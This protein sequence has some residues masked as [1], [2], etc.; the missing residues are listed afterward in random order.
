LKLTAHGGGNKGMIFKQAGGG[1][2]SVFRWL[3][4][5]KKTQKERLINVY[6]VAGI[7][8]LIIIMI[9]QSGVASRLQCIGICFN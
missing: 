7:I 6:I 5:P 9:W 2:E 8:V 3:N 1:F 4:D